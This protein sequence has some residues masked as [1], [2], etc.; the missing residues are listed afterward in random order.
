MPPFI[1]FCP[2]SASLPNS[3]TC[4]LGSPLKQTTCTQILVSGRDSGTQTKMRREAFNPHVA[5][6]SL[7]LLERSW[8][9]GRKVTSQDRDIVWPRASWIELVQTLSPWCLLPLSPHAL[10]GRV[11][12]PPWSLDSLSSLFKFLVEFHKEAVS[13]QVH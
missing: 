4:F 7:A 12:H 11:A 8:P 6:S 3:L 1:A 5:T 10:C 2:T 13:R 9:G